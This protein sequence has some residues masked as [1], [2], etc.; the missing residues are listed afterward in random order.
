M[1]A[2]HNDMGVVAAATEQRLKECFRAVR[3]LTFDDYNQPIVILGPD[4]DSSGIY[5]VMPTFTN[6]GLNMELTA[7]GA[8]RFKSASS[9]KGSATPSGAEESSDESSDNSAKIK[10]VGKKRKRRLSE[11][12]QGRGCWRRGQGNSAMLVSCH[13]DVRPRRRL[14]SR[15]WVCFYP[16]QNQERHH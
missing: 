6:A 12:L 16:Y 13:W 1:T 5:G 8:S 3:C 2:W 15:R 10:V 4:G 9:F 11:G 14:C 7:E